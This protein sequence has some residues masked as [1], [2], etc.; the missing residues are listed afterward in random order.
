LLGAP[1]KGQP[2]VG[3][4]VVVELHDERKSAYALG[5]LTKSGTQAMALLEADI[6][7]P[8]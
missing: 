5:A 2:E 8:P 3:D 6:V 4:R 7:R 1:A